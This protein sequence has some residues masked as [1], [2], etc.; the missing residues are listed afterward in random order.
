MKINNRFGASPLSFIMMMAVACLTFSQVLPASAQTG[1]QL[2]GTLQDGG[3]A[4]GTFDLNAAGD[5]ITAWNI[6][7]SADLS[8]PAY[9]NFTYS[10]TNGGF[11][12]LTTGI[13]SFFSSSFARDMALVFSTPL[14]SSVQSESL[15]ANPGTF[16]TSE[17][18]IVEPDLQDPRYFVSGSV[19][20]IPVPE[21]GTMVSFAFGIVT[22]MSVALIKQI[23]TGRVLLADL[24][25]ES[26][27]QSH[28]DLV[29]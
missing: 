12:F 5:T 25:R 6:N 26:A 11:S 29:G 22:L 20:Q 9:T 14:S 7:F 13:Y 24:R 16:L 23:R 19:T 17:E 27:T 2:N 8:D 1:W 21:P 18:Q 15:V 28:A 4:T 10:N 3:T